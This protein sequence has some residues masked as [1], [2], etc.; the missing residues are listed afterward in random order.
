MVA[1]QLLQRPAVFVLRAKCEAR[2]RLERG[3]RFLDGRPIQENK[4]V[5]PEEEICRIDNL[6]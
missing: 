2:S 5:F 1:L 3:V 6:R 4:D